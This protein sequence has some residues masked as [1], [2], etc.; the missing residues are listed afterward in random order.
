MTEPGEKGVGALL[1]ESVQQV[2]RTASRELLPLPI[3]FP[4]N[5]HVES[6]QLHSL[7]RAVRS[8]VMRRVGWQGRPDDGVRSM[9]EISRRRRRR[10]EVGR[11]RFSSLLYLE[12]A[13]L[14]RR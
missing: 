4:E 5:E 9:D 13:L 7:S 2:N 1:T 14:T 8:L 6:E 10:L 12:F 3:P 11:L